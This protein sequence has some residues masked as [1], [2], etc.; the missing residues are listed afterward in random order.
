MSQLLYQNDE[1]DECMLYVKSISNSDSWKCAIC[2][3]KE[4]QIFL[5]EKDG[6][7]I[8][9]RYGLECN[10]QVHMRCY[11]VWCKTNNCVGCPKCGKKDRN[12]T[13]RFCQHCKCFGH[14]AH[15]CPIAEDIRIKEYLVSLTGSYCPK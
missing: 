3:L 8:W 9:D 6:Y 11:R 14:P 7:Y 10:H 2:D 12:A 4:S 1:C 15:L 5:S 13:N